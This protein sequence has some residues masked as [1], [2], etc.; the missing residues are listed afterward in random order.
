MLELLRSLYEEGI[1]FLELLASLPLEEEREVF[2]SFGA[3][4]SPSDPP[5]GSPR[6]RRRLIIGKANHKERKEEL[7]MPNHRD[8]HP[9]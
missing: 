6:R 9:K 5:T 7:T 2:I 4:D 3:N 1:L 8:K